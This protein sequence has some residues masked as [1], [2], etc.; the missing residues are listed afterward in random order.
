METR[1]ACNAKPDMGETKES[2]ST[3]ANLTWRV[4]KPSEGRKQGK[5]ERQRIRKRTMMLLQWV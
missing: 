4:M 3:S 5:E 2:S 1:E